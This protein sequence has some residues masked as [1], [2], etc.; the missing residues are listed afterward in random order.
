MAVSNL[1]AG[2]GIPSSDRPLSNVVFGGRIRGP[3]QRGS[4]SNVVVP[5]SN[6]MLDESRSWAQRHF[7]RRVGSTRPVTVVTFVGIW[8]RGIRAVPGGLPAPL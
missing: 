6:H 3:N 4:V 1:G 7:K 2:W 8:S 5:E